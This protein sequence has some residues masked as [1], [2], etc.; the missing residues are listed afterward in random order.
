MEDD[1]DQLVKAN[2]L[3]EEEDM[4]VNEDIYE[5]VSSH[6]ENPE[7]SDVYEETDN[8]NESI[9]AVQIDNK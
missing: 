3:K 8:I 1:S 9:P 2:T 5:E 6:G 7:I 4:I